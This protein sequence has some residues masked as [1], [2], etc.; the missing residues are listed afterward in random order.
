MLDLACHIDTI[1]EVYYNNKLVSVAKAEMITSKA[2]L[3]RANQ[4]CKYISLNVLDIIS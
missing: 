4:I 3:V 1:N 2:T